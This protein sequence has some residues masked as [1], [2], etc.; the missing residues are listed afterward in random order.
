MTESK[1][2][3]VAYLLFVCQMLGEKIISNKA[4]V[5]GDIGITNIL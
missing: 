3:S 1:L 2:E 4:A 5:S